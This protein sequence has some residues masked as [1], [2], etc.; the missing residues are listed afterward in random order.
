MPI[1]VRF[2]SPEKAEDFQ[3]KIGSFAIL[4]STLIQGT[5]MAYQRKPIKLT[6]K[7][8]LVI[9]G[10]SFVVTFAGVSILRQVFIPK[11]EMDCYNRV[12][13]I[14][15]AV[16]QWN[17]V[18]SDKIIKEDIDEAGLAKEGFLQPLT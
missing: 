11:E 1:G 15:K 10:L 5:R 14:Q 7:S 9:F 16:D 6:W 13:T 12:I 3:R 17:K 2:S 8:G 18:H 4:S